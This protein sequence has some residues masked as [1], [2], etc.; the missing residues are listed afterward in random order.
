[1]RIDACYDSHV[2]WAAT[3]EF[4]GR[5]KLSDLKSPVDVKDLKPDHGSR[6][7]DWLLGFGWDQS[8]WD[9]QPTRAHLDLLWPDTP[10]AFSRCDG[11]VLWVNSA[12]LNLAGML[13]KHPAAVE[14]GRIELDDEGWPTG[15]LLDQARAAIDK[16]I[17]KPSAFDVRR[18]LLK[19]ANIFNRAGFTHIRDMTCDPQQWNE[20]AHIDEAGLLTLAVEEYLW[21]QSMDQLDAQ[22]EFAKQ[23]RQA[24]PGNLRMMG[25][26]VFYD[27]ALGSEGALLSRCYHDSTQH[28]L[29]LWETAALKEVFIRAWDQGLGVAVHSIGDQASDE[30]VS[31]AQ[32][33]ASAGQRGALHL[34]HAQILR[35]TTIEKMKGLRVECHLQPS[36][37][38][39]DHEWLEG[40]VGDLAKEAFPWRRLQEAEVPFDFGSDAPIDPP[41]LARTFQAL[42]ESAEAG[43]PRLLGMP[44]THMS[45]RDLA[46]APNSYTELDGDTPKHVVFRGEHLI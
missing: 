33:L 12:A 40:K 42:R 32:E 26:K 36:H 13:H 11:H 22:L 21:L 24:G 41:S 17:P 5:L 16:L 29:K 20:A 6:R 18:H 37:W 19:A 7:G 23:A 1:M 30:L 43:V 46:W 2:H 10:V 31:I 9:L 45:H 35:S 28:G 8:K 44:A 38:L 34:E 39:T 14:G 27:G 4:S 15:I 25:L 3:G